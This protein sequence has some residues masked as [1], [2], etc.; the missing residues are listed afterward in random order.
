MVGIAWVVECVEQRKQVDESKFLVDLSDIQVAVV[1]KV[2]RDQP[3]LSSLLN[4]S[5]FS[6]ANHCFQSLWLTNLT[7][8]L[9]ENLI[10]AQ[11]KTVTDQ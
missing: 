1:N 10:M 6:V 5:F 7:V 4:S 3:I 11:K 9:P 2:T 8:L